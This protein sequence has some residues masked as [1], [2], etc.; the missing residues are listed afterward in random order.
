MSA[1][2]EALGRPRSSSSRSLAGTLEATLGMGTL[3]MDKEEMRILKVCFYSNSFNMGK[4]FK[5]VKCPVT[6]EIR[7]CGQ[8]GGQ[9]RGGG[10]FCPPSIK[11]APFPDTLSHDMVAPRAL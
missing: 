7:V 10:L 5:L 2:P 8:G 11:L 3:E 1:I 4:N 6:T 9:G